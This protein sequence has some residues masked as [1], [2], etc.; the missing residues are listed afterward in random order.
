MRRHLILSAAFVFFAFV[1]CSEETTSRSE[2]IGSSTVVEGG[3][4]QDQG[5]LED[6][7]TDTDSDS[8]TEQDR[9]SASGSLDEGTGDG[10]TAETTGE[11]TDEG[12]GD[13][14]TFEPADDFPASGWKMALV[15]NFHTCALDENSRLY[16]WGA[17]EY[18]EAG[19]GNR[20]EELYSPCAIGDASWKLIAPGN[21]YT[22][23]ITQDDDLLCWGRSFWGQTGTS[24]SDTNEGVHVPTPVVQGGKWKDIATGTEHTCGIKTD[25]T[26]WCWGTNYSGQLGIGEMGSPKSRPIA[27]ATDITDW[28]SVDV[29]YQQT[30][31]IRSTGALYCF[32]RLYNEQFYFDEFKKEPVP[33]FEDTSWKSI[34]LGEDYRCGVQADDGLYC[35][36]ENG[37]GQL[38]FGERNAGYQKM[39]RIGSDTWKQVA[40]GELHTCGVTLGGELYCWGYQQGG[41]IGNGKNIKEHALTPQKIGNESNWHSVSVGEW[42]TCALNQ[43]GEIYCFGTNDYG[44]VGVGEKDEVITTPTRVE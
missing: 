21:D 43:E 18:G 19:N 17:N 7:G 9:D 24:Q 37:D 3:T 44:Q 35:W 23:G 12:T 39:Q 2:D 31:A 40:A 4:S 26:L 13:T 42:H 1:S 32:G 29:D 25:G 15:G 20:D 33:V 5:T 22:C 10:A 36:G 30:C 11:T 8:M 41:R 6:Q 14:G 16:C 34:A 38:G 27:V 28:V